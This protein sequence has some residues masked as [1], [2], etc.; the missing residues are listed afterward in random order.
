MTIGGI[1]IIINIINI[2]TTSSLRR[3]QIIVTVS[4][5]VGLSFFL[6]NRRALD[7][8]EKAQVDQVD[9]VDQVGFFY[10]LL[11]RL[12]ENRKMLGRKALVRDVQLQDWVVLQIRQS[13]SEF[14]VDT[15]KVLENLKTDVPSVSTAS[16]FV[17]HAANIESLQER[18]AEWAID[19]NDEQAHLATRVF[20]DSDGAGFGSPGGSR[21]KGASLSS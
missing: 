4:L 8:A 18:V 19:I 11:W 9:Q 3:S 12:N 17:A 10:D 2:A 15:Q 14:F 13:R 20:P 7:D 16:I 21:Q 1:Y 5:L 6:V